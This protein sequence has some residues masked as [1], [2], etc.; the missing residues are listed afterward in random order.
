M[1]P[2]DI[3]PLSKTSFGEKLPPSLFQTSGPTQ[4]QYISFQA[5]KAPSWTT[6]IP[7]EQYNGIILELFLDGNA[8]F[9][10]GVRSEICD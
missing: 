9:K 5:N 2:F 10:F 7:K 3:S 4:R 8:G 1:I 6:Q